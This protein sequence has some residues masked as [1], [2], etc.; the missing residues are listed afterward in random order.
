MSLTLTLIS[1]FIVLLLINLIFYS[2]ENF[3]DEQ[4]GIDS[5]NKSDSN[6]SGDSNLSED[7][8]D[9]VDSMDKKLDDLVEQEKETRTF[10]KLLRHDSSNKEQMKKI[11]EY[12]NK[13]FEDNWKKQNKMLTDIKKK[14]I[15]VKLG[16]DNK[17]FSDFNTD[18]NKKREGNKKREKIME[19]AK[20]MIQKPPQINL[21]FQNNM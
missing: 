10:C 3:I 4:G 16:K 9:K 2:S 11:M 20:K 7:M 15:E 1:V 12:R 8:L 17:D 13:Q 18:R 19:V 6:L 21:T 5:E 14:I